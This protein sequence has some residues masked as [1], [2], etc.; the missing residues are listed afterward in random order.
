MEYDN[1]YAFLLEKLEKSGFQAYLV[2]GCVR[3]MLLGRSVGDFDIATNALPGQIAEVFSGLR[4]IPT[5]IKHGTV[6]VIYDSAPFEMTTF[7]V[8]GGYSD[9][10]RPDSVSFTPCLEEDLA[11]RDLTVNAMAMDKNGNITDPFGGLADLK[12][13]RL[14]CVGD[15]AKRFSEDALRILRMVRF[16]SVL[17]FEADNATAEA[18]LEMRGSLD[19]ISRE[20]CRDELEKTIMGESFTA[21]ALKYRDILAQ[22]VP[23]LRPCFDFDQRSRY[24]RYDVYEHTV[25]AVS[26][27][28]F[29]RIVRTAMLFHDIGKPSMFTLDE[30]GVGHFKGHA[31]V[32]AEIAETVMKRLRYDNDTISQVCNVIARHSDEIV[33]EKQVKRLISKLGEETFFLLIEAKKADNLAKRDFV[34]EENEVFD[35]F[36]ET[37]RQLIQA[38]SCMSL[39]QLAVNGN[40][41]TALGVKGRAVGECLGALLELVVDGVLPN[42]SSALIG[43]AKEKLI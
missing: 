37:A 15:P 31:G 21:A 4:V 2:G 34:L 41:M 5:G 1:K 43:Y 42:E 36:A 35:S 3:D 14:K 23:E 10:R 27:A 18:A 38:D 33:S 28:P 12:A 9:S 26:A 40:D 11:R 8:D 13:R 30:N 39:K 20:R 19:G 16:S 24:H 6:T 32:S 29:D 22:I 25:R 17:G 7:R